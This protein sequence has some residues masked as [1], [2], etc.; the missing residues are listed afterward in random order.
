MVWMLRP[1]DQPFLPAVGFEQD[2][3]QEMVYFS[4]SRHDVQLVQE[5]S[6]AARSIEETLLAEQF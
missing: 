6:R 3:C 1:T 4:H 2:A 5:S